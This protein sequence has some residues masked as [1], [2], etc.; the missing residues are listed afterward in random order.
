MYDYKNVLNLVEAME[1]FRLL[2]ATRVAIYRTNCDSD[3]QKVLDYYVAQGFIEVIPWTI[4]KH[5]KVSSGW[6]KDISGGELHYY[7]QIPAL[8]DC[9][10][11][12][13]YQSQYVALHDMDE[14]ILPFGVKTWTEM[15]P[16]LEKTYG[17]SLGFEFENNQ[18]PFTSKDNG[19][20]DV[21][22]WESV[23]GTNILKYI[24]RVPN[25][26]KAF[27]NYKV[28]VNPRLVLMATVHGLLDTVNLGQHTVRVDRDVA[29]MYHSKNF[30]YPLNTNLITDYRLWDY[31]DELIPAVTK[32]LQDCGFITG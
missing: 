18:F 22:Q 26:P 12:Y 7:G 25:N 32:V 15:L 3:V 28:I 1:M 24:Q 8:N 10:Y 29:R 20:Y 11:R 17:D 19:K 30:T 27:N 23:R 6:R 5:V 13:M 2:G 31:A 9:V 21:R 16:K 4:K 14:L